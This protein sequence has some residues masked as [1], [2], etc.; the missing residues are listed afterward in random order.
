MRVGEL[1]L[2]YKT[3]SFLKLFLEVS[4]NK[5]YL[6][7]GYRGYIGQGYAG[8]YRVWGFRELG[9]PCRGPP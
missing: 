5:V 1:L 2:G 4:S 8:I 3:G 7:G 6:F 9:V